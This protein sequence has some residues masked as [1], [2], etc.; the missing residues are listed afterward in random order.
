MDLNELRDIAKAGG[1]LPPPEPVEPADLRRYWEFMQ[2]FQAEH[3]R[4]E[5]GTIGWDVRLIEAEFPGMDWVPVWLRAA[6]LQV[7]RHEGV[8]EEWE[9]AEELDA[10]V[11][12]VAAAFPFEGHT[13]DTEAFRE[14]VRHEKD[15][16]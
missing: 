15:A 11:F 6:C 5:G 4:P 3:P 1:G 7:L 13:I 14:Q 16:H 2:K 10:A 8:V 9:T 12:K